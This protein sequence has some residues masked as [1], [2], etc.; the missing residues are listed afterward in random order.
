M[1]ADYISDYTLVCIVLN[2]PWL[3]YN[4]REKIF[5]YDA[6]FPVHII[7]RKKSFCEICLEAHSGKCHINL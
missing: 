3:L 1:A 5:L 2:S 4:S 7:S 6:L